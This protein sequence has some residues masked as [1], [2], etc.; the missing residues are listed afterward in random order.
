MTAVYVHIPYCKSKCPYCDFASIAADANIESY[1]GALVK[2]ALN[3]SRTISPAE[4]IYVGG[5]TPSILSAEQICWLCEQL[6]RII[7]VSPLAEVTFE[8]NPCSLTAAKA[9][10]LAGNGVNRVSLGAQSFVDAELS[11]LGR[12]H[13]AQ[14]IAD[15]LLALRGAGIDNLSL[16][17]IYA[18]PNQ[19]LE[20]WRYS[21]ERA[22]ELKP[23]HVS[24]YCL[25]FEQPTP[26]WQ[27]LQSGEIQKKLDEEELEFY[28]VAREMLLNAGYEHYEISNFA[29]PGRRSRHNMVY[30]SNEEYLGL[31]ASAV[32]YLGVRRITNTRDPHAY[33]RVIEERG[34]AAEEIDEIS[35]RMQAIETIIQRLRLKDGIDCA[36]FQARFGL[37][38]TELFG[39]C[40]EELVESGLL[41]YSSNTI[42]PSLTGW[43][44]A[45]EIALR[46]LP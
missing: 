25:T 6:N 35:L 21:L 10:A 5:G 39:D 17:L 33:I 41:E 26:F 36:V 15:G 34:N 44:L 12:A 42:K 38:P 13:I 27:R 28:G 19:S 22:I 31:G 29:R 2:E 7:E 1:L 46:I 43:H 9:N 30:W 37:H 18:I 23:E 4:T 32:S 14:D 24:T 16:D 11:F 20:S 3:Q 40:L 45:N 8:A